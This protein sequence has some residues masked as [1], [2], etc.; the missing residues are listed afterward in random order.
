[1]TEKNILTA[2]MIHLQC[3]DCF[4]ELRREGNC[5]E[6]SRVEKDG[7]GIIRVGK[8]REGNCTGGKNDGSGFVPD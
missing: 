4:Y 8:R 6:L 2:N 5:P 1:M 3:I 7:R